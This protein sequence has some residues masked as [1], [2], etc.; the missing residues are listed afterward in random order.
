[1]LCLL[2][3]VIATV[4][5]DASA[6]VTCSYTEEY[7]YDV[8]DQFVFFECQEEGAPWEG[9]LGH[10]VEIFA[11]GET[12]SLDLKHSSPQIVWMYKFNW[13]IFKRLIFINVW[14]NF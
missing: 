3:N 5:R 7:N 4:I 9:V 14:I 2:D 1:M 6:S 12:P 13:V 8:D 11:R 10:S